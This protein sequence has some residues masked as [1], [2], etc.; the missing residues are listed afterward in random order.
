MSHVLHTA[1]TTTDKLACKLMYL[2][3]HTIQ[4][5]LPPANYLYVQNNWH[6][7]E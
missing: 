5:L 4:P 3:M 1:F 7:L 2:A 6:L